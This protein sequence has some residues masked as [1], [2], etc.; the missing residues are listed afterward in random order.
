MPNKVKSVSFPHIKYYSV[1]ADDRRRRRGKGDIMSDNGWY[2]I[3]EAL[4]YIKE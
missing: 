3:D 4:V 1:R 2:F